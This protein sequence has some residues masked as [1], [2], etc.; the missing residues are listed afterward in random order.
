MDTPAAPK[1]YMITKLPYA[2]EVTKGLGK[3]WLRCK[4]SAKKRGGASPKCH[5]EL[6]VGLTMGLALVSI[7]FFI[8]DS[9][10]VSRAVYS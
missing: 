10:S 2:E 1:E 6:A 4:I 9:G 5:P 8:I 3:W 7:V